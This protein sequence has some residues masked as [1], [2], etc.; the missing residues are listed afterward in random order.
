VSAVLALTS[1]TGLFVGG[2]VYEDAVAASVL[3]ELHSLRQ[4]EVCDAPQL[5]DQGLLACAALTG[6]TRLCVLCCGLSGAMPTYLEGNDPLYGEGCF[7]LREQ[8]GGR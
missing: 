6:L 3:A 4:L 2:A 7:L 5:T 1:L 8:V